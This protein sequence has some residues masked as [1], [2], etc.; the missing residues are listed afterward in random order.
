M[1]AA[2]MKKKEGNRIGRQGS[3]NKN[4]GEPATRVLLSSLSTRL[5]RDKQSGCKMALP[6]VS[7]PT[8]ILKGGFANQR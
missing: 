7:E 8:V 2:S 4:T 1:A 3:G 5:R 6:S